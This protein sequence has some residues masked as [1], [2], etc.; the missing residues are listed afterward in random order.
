MVNIGGNIRLPPVIL[1]KSTISNSP[2][3]PSNTSKIRS[4]SMMTKNIIKGIKNTFVGNESNTDKN[5]SKAMSLSNLY[6]SHNQAE[7]C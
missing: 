1:S 3:R 7:S 6:F 4:I 5:S 2:K